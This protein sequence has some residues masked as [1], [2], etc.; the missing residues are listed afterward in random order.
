MPIL[1][2]LF[3]IVCEF[4]VLKNRGAQFTR[5]AGNPP[6]PP[7]ALQPIF[8]GIRPILRHPIEDGGYFQQATATL[9]HVADSGGG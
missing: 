4:C 9:H 8:R 2:F 3:I 7:G 5:D 6:H 1:S